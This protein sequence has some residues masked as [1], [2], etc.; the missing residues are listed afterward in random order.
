MREVNDSTT[1]DFNVIST[2]FPN[3]FAIVEI[4]NVDYNIG[5]QVGK[6]LGLCDSFEEA[7]DISCSFDSRDTI[8]IEGLNRM[9]VLGG[10]A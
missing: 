5:E 6:I 8:V 7:W 10:F 9:S 3:E 1:R 4:V 2:L